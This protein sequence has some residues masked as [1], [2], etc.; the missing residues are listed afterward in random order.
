MRS[1]LYQ[2]YLSALYH[3]EPDPPFSE[4]RELVLA[5]GTEQKARVLY[6]YAA[7]IA[8]L[9]ALAVG[10]GRLNS[11]NH[12]TKTMKFQATEVPSATHSRITRAEQIFA[13]SA[14]NVQHSSACSLNG[15]EAVV[16]HNPVGTDST[17]PEFI[18]NALTPI[19]TSSEILTHQ[20]SMPIIVKLESVGAI[21]GRSK[22]SVFVSGDALVNS[23]GN[24]SS[25]LFGAIGVQYRLSDHSTAVLEVRQSELQRI[26]AGQAGGMRDTVLN[27][28]GQTF[29]STI[30]GP[31]ASSAVQ[32]VQLGSLDIGYR[33]LLF[34]E[35]KFSPVAEV[36]VGASSIGG[37]ASEAAGM[38]YSIN[39][40]L[41]FNLTA[42][43]IQLY[44]THSSPLNSSAIESSVAFAW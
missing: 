37:V 41:Q 12:V 3:A 5:S 17:P 29:R 28:G 25:S 42:R 33:F 16:L 15:Y 20:S 2:N 35:S 23:V 7:S 43:E 9:A 10:I 34:P 13:M 26:A 39:P 22:W 14:A 4:I 36:L 18:A 38:E 6:W 44:A 32:T 27:V 19:P 8:L 40:S 11:G 31:S 24:V 21:S 30:G 1:N